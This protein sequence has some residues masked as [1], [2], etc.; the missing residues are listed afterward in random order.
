M[1][2]STQICPCPAPKISAY[3]DSL[4]V[5]DTLEIVCYTME[6]N[7]IKYLIDDVEQDDADLTLVGTFLGLGLMGYVI[8]ITSDSEFYIYFNFAYLI[9]Y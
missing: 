3:D 5:G 7:D 1:I 6:G 4:A 9:L 8:V 2:I